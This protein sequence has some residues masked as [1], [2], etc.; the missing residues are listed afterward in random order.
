VRLPN[1]GRAAVPRAKLEGYLLSP[2]HIAGRGKARFF[3]GF[4]FSAESWEALG[5]ALVRHASSNE[6]KKVEE[7]PFGTKY[8]IDG[9]LEA[10]D[11]RR[12]VVRAVWFVERGET[13]PRFV[14]AY[15]RSR[16]IEP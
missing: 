7:T 8:T 12:P 4:G 5:E 3:S 14:T 9:P 13:D 1:A 11:G 16:R 15:P 6:V 10:P 2:S